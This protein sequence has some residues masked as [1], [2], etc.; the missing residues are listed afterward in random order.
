MKKILPVLIL[1]LVINSTQTKAEAVWCENCSEMW[2]Q[3][4]QWV[5]QQWEA[6]NQ[7]INTAANAT[8]QWKNTIQDPIMSALI[9]SAI[10]TTIQS[11]NRWKN[12]NFQGPPLVVVNPEIYLQ[13]AGNAAINAGLKQINT[14]NLLNKNIIVKNIVYKSRNEQKSIPERT[15][16][17]LAKDIR[18]DTCN[19]TNLYNM[20]YEEMS[21]IEDRNSPGFNS[22]VLTKKNEL[23]NNLCNGNKDAELTNCYNSGDGK[24]FSWTAWTND[25]PNNNPYTQSVRTAQLVQA[26]ADRKVALAANETK[27]GYTSQK[28]SK[29]ETVATAAITK[30]SDETASLGNIRRLLGM[31][32]KDATAS[33]LSQI[34]SSSISYLG[35]EANSTLSQ[36]GMINSGTI[37]DVAGSFGT[38]NG[39]SLSDIIVQQQLQNGTSTTSNMPADLS[40]IDKKALIDPMLER[41][42]RDISSLTA[43]KNTYPSYLSEIENDITQLDNSELA[44]CYNSMQNGATIYTARTT[45]S[46]LKKQ[47][48]DYYN[49]L[50]ANN[51]GSINSWETIISSRVNYLNELKTP[52]EDLIN[53]SNQGIATA[54][55]AS[56]NLIASNNKS[57]ITDIIYPAYERF[58]SEN[59]IP[60]QGSENY[61]EPKIAE[62]RIN[63][64]RYNT[65]TLTPTIT[66]CK[67][68]KTKMDKD[69][70][71]YMTQLSQRGWGGSWGIR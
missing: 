70:G 33:L 65:N 3:S 44:T 18:S 10:D 49:A 6:A 25:D 41:I 71:D 64:E 67:Q 66:S 28:N 40:D 22:R 69:M 57:E 48:G 13:N 8:N 36:S 14:S 47:I 21:N 58:S 37:L 1:C 16:P 62:L 53:K 54:K 12:G 35:K 11:L 51:Q 17:T 34:I 45:D 55:A 32:G 63:V 60:P 42:T 23:Y 30:A 50:L 29:G 2:T 43:I 68:T 24:C 27:D 15:R 52:T 19:D 9:N 26:D 39:I 59:P 56:A 61:V 4:Y 7:T 46:Y 31:S 5:K 38:K 20:A